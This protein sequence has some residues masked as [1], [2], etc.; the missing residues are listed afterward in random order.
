MLDLLVDVRLMR[1]VWRS[2]LE[3]SG[4]LS[5]M[6]AST[7]QAQML[8]AVSSTIMGPVSTTEYSNHSCMCV[9]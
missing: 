8:F 4:A 9:S 6:T 7:Q 5:V 2:A 3:K 1:D